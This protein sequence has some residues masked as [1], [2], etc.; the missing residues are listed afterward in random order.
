MCNRSFALPNKAICFK[1]TKTKTKIYV[2]PLSFKSS[3]SPSLVVG[4]QSW[5]KVWGNTVH[6][7]AQQ[8]RVLFYIISRKSDSDQLCYLIS[9]LSLTLFAIRVALLGSG[10][11]GYQHVALDGRWTEPLFGF[12]YERVFHLLYQ[13]VEEQIRQL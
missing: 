10:L 9:Y 7:Q 3:C 12:L 13:L 8:E 1:G 6:E 5:V 11:V 2:C 4:R